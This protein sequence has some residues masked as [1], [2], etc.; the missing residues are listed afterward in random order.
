MPVEFSSRLVG[1]SL[2]KQFHLGRRMGI[3]GLLNILLTGMGPM[4]RLIDPKNRGFVVSRLYIDAIQYVYKALQAIEADALM[5]NTKP[6]Y[7]EDIVVERTALIILQLIKEVAPR[8]FVGIY[9]DGIPPLAKVIEQR[10]RRYEMLSSTR[11]GAFNRAKITVGTAFVRQIIERVMTVLAENSASLPPEIDLSTATEPGEGEHKLASRIRDRDAAQPGT[12]VIAADDG[13]VMIMAL[14]NGWKDCYIY[15]DHAP[16]R[17]QHG[18]LSIAAV[19]ERVRARLNNTPTAVFDF[20]LMV[21][22]TGGNDFMPTIQAARNRRDILTELL[23]M[24]EPVLHGQPLMTDQGREIVW[25]SVRSLVVQLAQN[26][27]RS[28]Q[29]LAEYTKKKLQGKMPA[30][31]TRS[32]DPKTGSLRLPF[33]K[34]AWDEMLYEP[35]VSKSS[36]PEVIVIP[37]P[38]QREIDADHAFSA[39]LYL[40]GLAWT[41]GYMRTGDGPNWFYSAA[42]PPLFGDLAR[43]MATPGDPARA[44]RGLPPWEPQSLAV[45][46]LTILPRATTQDLFG[47]SFGNAFALGAG[48]Q[49]LFPLRFEHFAPAEWQVETRKGRAILPPLGLE[50]I[51]K[52]V[53]ER[54]DVAVIEANL[55]AMKPRVRYSRTHGDWAAVG[56]PSAGA[57]KVVK[58]PPACADYEMLDVVIPALQ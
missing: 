41:L 7:D 31:Y 49:D 20:C 40:Q 15:L 56:K 39:T 1:A 44:L 5:A 18:L 25:S 11:A 34:K 52:V 27:E 55:R 16:P 19:A 51:Q 32:M 30:L 10:A 58:P 46:L 50:R 2:P 23:D 35:K 28:L 29:R 22:L 37:K 6:V 43:V 33:F 9:F 3:R 12:K 48:L 8:N 53:T 24:Y 13:D 14:L 47:D 42:Y 4:L 38:T 45:Y 36:L 17:P 21:I 54:L 57:G 26:E